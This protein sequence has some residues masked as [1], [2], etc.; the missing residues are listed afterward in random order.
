LILKK[1]GDTLHPLIRAHLLKFS[2]V[3]NYFLK[4]VMEEEGYFNL[5]YGGRTFLAYCMIEG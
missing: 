4:H 3:T 1:K 2:F 5:V